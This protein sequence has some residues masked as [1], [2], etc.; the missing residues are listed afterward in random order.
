MKTSRKIACLAL[1][2]SG[3]LSLFSC[4]ENPNQGGG[5]GVTTLKVAF[6]KCG[7]GVD[8][9]TRWEEDYNA[10][11]PNAKIKI[12]RD[13]DAQMTA[14]ILPRL[15]S[16][17]NLPDLVMVLST[18]WQ[19]WS[20][21]GYLE[22]IDDVY[23]K[24]VKEDG[25]TVRDYIVDGLQDFGKVKGHYYALPWSV[26]P[27]GLIYNKK[28]FADY[29]WQVP[30]SFEELQTLCET[31]KADS[32]GT[33]APFSW[34][35]SVAS[36]WDFTVLQ[37]WAQYEGKAKW[38]EF[39]KFESPDV[40]KQEGRLKALQAFQD[41]ICTGE[42]KAKNSVP[43][44]AGKKFMEAQMSFVNGEAAMMS[45]GAWLENEMKS[46]MPAG[47]TMS[48]MKTPSLAGSK[49]KDA[50]YCTSGDFFVIPR[51][52]AN[53]EAAKKFL[54][55]TCT[56]D[57]ARIFTQSAGGIRPFRYKPSEIEGIS[58]FTK[59]CAL[60][61]EQSNNVYM[62][63]DSIMYYQNN[64]NTWPGYG[65]PYSKMVQEDDTAAEVHAQIVSFVASNWKAFQNEAGDFQ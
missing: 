24:K 25:T 4:S 55:Y 1:A 9:L 47:F 38:D 50:L 33:I 46:S 59:E 62:T 11:N 53:K 20:V 12:D 41:L 61:W 18:N 23:G 45:N 19:P 28:M 5:D 64:L 65:S 40:F 14:N 58:G 15:Q 63:S 57:A 34:S 16:G 39:W 26:N 31:I 10:K 60:M 13:G 36:Y 44:A 30:T 51:G 43:G 8:F 2:F 37:W 6:A 17:R 22:P 3:A 42:G 35:G 32:S 29:A 49:E 54:A 56:P 48:L 27:C 52:A 7:F 21:Q